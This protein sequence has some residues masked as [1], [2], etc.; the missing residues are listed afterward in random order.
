MFTRRVHPDKESEIS[1]VLANVLT[2]HQSIRSNCYLTSLFRQ[3]A[4]WYIW[5]SGDQIDVL[6]CSVETK[7]QH[8][9]LTLLCFPLPKPIHT[10]PLALVPVL[11]TADPCRL[12]WGLP[13]TRSTMCVTHIRCFATFC[14]TCDFQCTV[15][16]WNRSVNFIFLFVC[17]QSGSTPPKGRTAPTN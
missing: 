3:F 11:M 9:T 13:I 14:G 6:Q 2:L 12:H 7:G 5:A 8:P 1:R 4:C 17:N 10:A 16:K 15:F